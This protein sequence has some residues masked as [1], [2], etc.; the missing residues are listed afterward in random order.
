MSA[1]ATS[2]AVPTGVTEPLRL[3][4]DD[5]P[6]ARTLG[7]VGARVPLP[8]SALTLAAVV[9]LLVLVV[10]EGAAASEAL[11][12]AA[13]AW[14]VLAGGLASGRPARDRFVWAVPAA[15]RFGEYVGIVWLGA[16]AAASSDPA[17]FALV[18]ALAFRHYD[19]VYRLRHQS[20]VPPAWVGMVA[21]GWEGRLIVAWV[22]MAAGALPAGFYVVAGVLGALFVG[23]S[24]ASWRR[25]EQRGHGG[26]YEDGDEEEAG[27]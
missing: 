18:C 27:G 11:A 13:V 9:P 17:A 4:R 26:S 8:Q 6:L 12:A 1:V 7:T 15:L 20:S 10:I 14:L 25:F 21:G 22:L 5:G 3:Y 16:I 2:S 23:E 24:V 19:L